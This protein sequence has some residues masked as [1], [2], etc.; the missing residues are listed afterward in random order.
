MNAYLENLGE[1]CS[2]NQLVASHPPDIQAVR[3]SMISLLCSLSPM[4]P[5]HVKV[6]QVILEKLIEKYRDVQKSSPVTVFPNSLVHRNKNR[7]VQ[8]IL[9]LE[10]FI[11]EVYYYS[12]KTFSDDN[13]IIYIL[14]YITSWVIHGS[15]VMVL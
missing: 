14:L 12:S 15:L 9:L 8:T 7:I 13:G 2:S 6:V 11:V 1:E 3:A 10:P 5:G 4:S